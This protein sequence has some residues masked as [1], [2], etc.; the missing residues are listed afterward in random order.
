M[1]LDKMLVLINWGFLLWYKK[2]IILMV[3][4]IPDVY[5]GL[6]H[7]KILPWF[8]LILPWF[9]KFFNSIGILNWY[10]YNMMQVIS[11]N[12]IGD[13]NIPGLRFSSWYVEARC[14][15]PM[16]IY[17]YVCNIHILLCIINNINA[18]L[19]RSVNLQER[20]RLLSLVPV[21]SLGTEKL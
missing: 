20:S 19:S 14:N 6:I 9:N 15:W 1:Y 10:I 4:V 3:S 18:I 2:G 5:P 21:P 11:W 8:K 7:C 17:I 12:N 16:A 13:T